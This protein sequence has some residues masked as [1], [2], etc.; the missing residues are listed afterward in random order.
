MNRRCYVL[1]VVLTLVTISSPNSNAQVNTGVVLGVVTDAS[2]A[3]VPGAA[4]ML[5]NVGT[6]AS[7]SAETGAT[8]NYSFP[9]VPVGEYELTV[10]R[11]GFKTY[12]H[13]RFSVSAFENLRIDAVLVIGQ[14]SQEVS[15]TAAPPTVDTVTASQGNTVTGT[16]LNG[17]PLDS[18]LWTQLVNLEP[19]VSSPLVQTPGFGSNAGISFS[20]NGVRSDE[21]NVMVDGVRNLDTFGGNAFVTPNLYAVSEFRFENN[22]YSAASGRDAGA[23]VNLIS[24]SG[25]NQ[26]HGNAF[27]YFRND[28]L[29]ARNFF[30][31]TVPE[32]RYNDFG[33]D[34]GGPI[35]KERVFFFWSEE[36]RR[37]IQSSG[38][39]LTTVAS[40]AQIG[41]VFQ[42]VTL[43]N[44]SGATAPGGAPCVTTSGPSSNATSAINPGCIDPNAV[45]LLQNYFPAPVSGLAAPFNFVSSVPDSTRWREEQIRLDANFSSKWRGYGR[46]TQDNVRLYNPYGLFNTNILPTVGAS[47]QFFP[48]Y[49]YSAHATYL[50]TPNMVSEFSWGLYW[51]TDKFLE[52]TSASCRCNVPALNIPQIFPLNE[53]DRIPT[54]SFAQGYAGINE[55]WFFHNYAFSM[56]I[57]YAST[58]IRGNHT[59]KFGVTYTPEGKSELANPSNNNTNG[60]FSFTGQYTGN[61]LADFLMGRASQY[62]ETAL[63]D[64]NNY[65]WYNLEPYFEDQVKLRPNLTLT[66]GLRYEYYSPE[67]ELMNHFGSFD[68]SL[69]NPAQAPVVNSS[70]VIKSPSGTYNSL[71]GI[72]VA[73]T[74]SPYGDHLFPA[75]Y[76]NLAPRL[77]LVWDPTKDGKTSVRAGYG[78]FYDRWG[79][80]TQ[81]GGF[82]PPFNS[83]VDIFNTFLSNPSGSSGSTPPNFPPALD[84]SLPP[85]KY[86]QVQ[87]WSVSV[88][89][90]VRA[91]TSVEAAYVGTK[92]THLLA[93]INLNQP[94]PNAEVADGTISPDSVRP[95]PGWSSITAW[96]TGFNSSYNSL[97]ISAIHRLQHGLAFQAAYTWSKTLT[98]ASSAWGTPQDSRDIKAEKG[99]ASFN[100]PQA[101]V[102]NYVWDIPFFHEK[103]GAEKA[104]LDGWEIS[105]ITTFQKGTPGT[106]TLPTDNEG[107]GF[108]G[109][110]RPNLVG[111][112]NAAAHS[113]TNWFNT[114]AFAVPPIAT[115]GD[116]PNGVIGLPGENNWDFGASKMIPIRESLNMR[117]RAQFFNFFNHPSFNSADTGYGDLAFGQVVS[118]LNPRIIQFSLEFAF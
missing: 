117:F 36:W 10:T 76:N 12:M 7:L 11:S 38:T 103:S 34:V 106:V 79:S 86:P 44:P 73:G 1:V 69:F 27:E 18:R 84:A 13:E 102:F 118:A 98:D 33:Y 30:S 8:G 16:Q 109:P 71:N 67:H 20:A 88:Q 111:N 89:R 14:V 93:P 65:R 80:Y 45:L 110:E 115:F 29:N 17:L 62:T 95:F 64:F 24:R 55:Q 26:F 99:L 22:S 40:P 74:N 105:G 58:W 23:Q 63:D 21:N 90:E 57:V 61:A 9:V 4:V 101:V 104:I 113:L 35:K 51:A 59:F 54:L 37:I 60:T 108:S 91:G 72:I 85:W 25:S 47:N 77:G 2:G 53:L 28:V 52:N 96:N 41:G 112:P 56:P 46:F 3:T 48:I 66:A 107:T 92:G 75:R 114:A 19:G 81:F 6:G 97:Q 116:A 68:P 50:P 39:F 82:N 43:T 5:R 32:N 87:K 100:V 49:N 15:V 78:V 70:G 42:G 31:P 83:S 94:Y